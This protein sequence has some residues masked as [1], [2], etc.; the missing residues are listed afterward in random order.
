M[1]KLNRSNTKLAKNTKKPKKTQRQ[2]VHENRQ[3]KNTVTYFYELAKTYAQVLTLV[4]EVY[5]PEDKD[6]F[7]KP[8]FDKLEEQQNQNKK[9]GEN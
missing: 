9:Q 5:N 1:K 6:G 4:A 2:L 3:L 8:F 7:L